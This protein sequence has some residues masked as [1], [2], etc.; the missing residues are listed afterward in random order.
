[1]EEGI[2]VAGNNK[3][4]QLVKQSQV[5]VILTPIEIPCKLA[6]LSSYSTY[7]DH[8]VKVDSSYRAFEIGIPCGYQEPLKNWTQINFSENSYNIF[9]SAVCGSSYTLYNVLASNPYCSMIKKNWQT[10]KKIHFIFLVVAKH[11]PP[12]TPMIQFFS[13]TLILINF[14]KPCHLNM[15]CQYK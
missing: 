9:F 12:S 6:D 7:S 2:I 4:H 1:M 10:L 5:E 8:S 11:L 15:A 3:N 13:S 14:T